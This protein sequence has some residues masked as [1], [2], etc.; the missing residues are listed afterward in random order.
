MAQDRGHKRFWCA[1]WAPLWVLNASE[2]S[3]EEAEPREGL[4]SGDGFNRTLALFEIATSVDAAL[5]I[6]LSYFIV[7]KTIYRYLRASECNRRTGKKP[8]QDMVDQQQQQQQPTRTVRVGAERAL[9]M[10]RNGSK[11]SNSRKPWGFDCTRTR[12]WMMISLGRTTAI[13]I[14]KYMTHLPNQG[15]AGTRSST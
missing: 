5:C 1:L 15:R 14:V 9:A 4:K 13:Y 7:I 12:Q 3:P 6:T 8:K 10:L 2:R 11:N